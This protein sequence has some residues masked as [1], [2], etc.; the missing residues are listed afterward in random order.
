MSRIIFLDDFEEFI[1]YVK[2][3]REDFD[4]FNVSV[5]E[6]IFVAFAEYVKL[7]S[8]QGGEDG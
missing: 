1:A 3:H 2:A 4:D 8:K 7:K 5:V 6:S